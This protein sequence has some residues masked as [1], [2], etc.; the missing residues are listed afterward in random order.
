[1]RDLRPQT[2][3]DELQTEMKRAGIELEV[4]N[5]EAVLWEQAAVDA[6]VAPR[7]N[8]FGRTEKALQR[9]LDALQTEFEQF[10]PD[11]VF[12]IGECVDVVLRFWLDQPENA[13]PPLRQI[14]RSP[15]K[16]D[17]ESVKTAVQ[18]P[19]IEGGSNYF[20]YNFE[21]KTVQRALWIAENSNAGV[22]A[23]ASEFFAQ[24]GIDAR[25]I[26]VEGT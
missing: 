6:P 13:R 2:L 11:T 4:L 1:L 17:G 24:S 14:T 16:V 5:L 22:G 23:Q 26:V 9:A 15:W 12:M 25:G 20:L 10:R 3:R 7:F 19:A 18:F 8:P 21:P